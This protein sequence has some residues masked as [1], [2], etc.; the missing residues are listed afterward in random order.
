MAIRL[1]FIHLGTLLTPTSIAAST[2]Q[3]RAEHEYDYVIAGGGLTGLVAAA[4]LSEDPN[5]ELHS[6]STAEK[7]PNTLLTLVICNSNCPST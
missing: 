5:G 1:S 7:G 2:H 4:R 6:L 3:K